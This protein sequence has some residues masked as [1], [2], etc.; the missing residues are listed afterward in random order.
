MVESSSKQFTLRMPIPLSLSHSL[1][2][3]LRCA[4]PRRASM[5]ATRAS[6]NESAAPPTK[7]AKMEEVLPSLRVKKL[8]PHAKLPVRGSA[9]SAGYDLAR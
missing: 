8:V 5:L 7:L 9:G 4:V 3:A 2:R 6:A 1:T